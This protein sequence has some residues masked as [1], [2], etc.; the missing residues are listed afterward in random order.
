M[1]QRAQPSDDERRT[2]ADDDCDP[3]DHDRKAGV[4]PH[5]NED[6]EPDDQDER[7]LVPGERPARELL[8]ARHPRR[9][10]CSRVA[11]ARSAEAHGDGVPGRVDGPHREASAPATPR[12]T[13]WNRSAAVCDQDATGVPAWRSPRRAPGVATARPPVPAHQD[14]SS[15]R[16]SSPIARR[17]IDAVRVT[18]SASRNLSCGGRRSVASCSGTHDDAARTRRA[19]AA[20]GAELGSAGR[21]AHGGRGPSIAVFL[22][23][24][25]AHA[26]LDARSSTNP[27]A[28]ARRSRSGAR[29]P[30]QARTSS[31]SSDPSRTVLVNQRRV[32]TRRLRSSWPV[33]GVPALVA[34]RPALE[35]SRRARTPPT[36]DPS[37]P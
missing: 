21:S 10:R 5:T 24:E 12:T 8:R 37:L 25:Q 11:W 29:G 19:A 20:R 7:R 16:V 4:P 31:P 35:R 28:G 27:R 13:I 3:V 6:V 17:A 22:R 15:M 18:R 36:W 30:E 2:T 9:A 32:G 23:A 34:Q 14:G 1:E 26:D 33:E